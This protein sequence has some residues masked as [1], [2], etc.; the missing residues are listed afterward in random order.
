MTRDSTN[1]TDKGKIIIYI[2][3]YLDISL[4]PVKHMFVEKTKKI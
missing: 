4:E 2:E 3:F 1:L